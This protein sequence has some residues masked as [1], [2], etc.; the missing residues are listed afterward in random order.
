MRDKMRNVLH[1]LDENPKGRDRLEYA[2]V[3]E[4]IIPKC[5]IAR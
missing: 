4:K 5:I 3:D 1:I 2:D